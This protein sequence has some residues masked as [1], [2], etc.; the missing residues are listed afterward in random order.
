MKAIVLDDLK[1]KQRLYSLAKTVA[2]PV[3]I[4]LSV[5]MLYF[6]ICLATP[7]L[8]LSSVGG[9]IGQMTFRLANGLR[10]FFLTS[11]AIGFGTTLGSNLW[12]AYSGKLDP[13]RFITSPLLGLAG[14]GVWLIARKL[15]RTVVKDIALLAGY[16]VVTSTIVTLRLAT[17]ASFF[18]TT[19]WLPIFESAFIWKVTSTFLV[20]LI[21]YPFVRGYEKVRENYKKDRNASA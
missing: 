3:S 21:G 15:N 11:P 16:A 8:S 18:Y 10:A 20:L 1:N 13:T 7:G 6:M 5:S 17:W 14:F 4:T 19:A 9:P 12:N 2:I